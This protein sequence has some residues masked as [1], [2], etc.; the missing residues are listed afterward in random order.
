VNDL[1]RPDRQRTETAMFT[2]PYIASKLDHDRHRDMRADIAQ[3]RVARQLRNLATASRR[4][5][6]IPLRQ[7]RTWRPVLRLRARARA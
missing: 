5:G 2:H 1:I 7:R 4:A 3:Q 6:G